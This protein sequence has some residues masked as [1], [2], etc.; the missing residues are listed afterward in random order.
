MSNEAAGDYKHKDQ[1]PGRAGRVVAAA[2]GRGFDSDAG[3][4][5][6][7]PRLFRG[8]Q[9]QCSMPTRLII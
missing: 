9:V 1:P 2:S 8:S 3:A 7:I 4:T 5:S 6:N